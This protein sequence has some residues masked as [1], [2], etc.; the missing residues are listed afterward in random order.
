[1]KFFRYGEVGKEKP[2]ILDKDG[3]H[4]DLSRHVSDITPKNFAQLL[5]L[6]DENIS[7]LPTIDKPER[8]GA[9]VTGVGKFICIGLNYIDHAKESGMAL[10]SEPVSFMKATSALCGP[11]D[12]ILIPRNSQKTD[13]E[14]ELAVVI[15]KDGKYIDEGSAW[16]YIAGYCVTNDLSEREFQLEREGNWSKG[17]SCD[18]FGP[19]GPY[20]VTSEEIK[21]PHQLNMWLKVNGQIMQNSSSSQMFYKIPYLI[22]YMSQFMSLK[23]GDIIST[24]TPP[25]VG[26]GFNPPV[27]LK[28]G[29]LVSLGIDGLGEQQQVAIQEK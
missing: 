22:S 1:M 5:T 8:F 14:V 12:P 27:Y 20:L 26:L 13:W 23:A 24:G 15:K 19:I 16:E 11:N 2:G 28:E 29:D 10:P 21:D 6:T 4:R 3:Q 17:K 25:G 9:C 18:N 7:A